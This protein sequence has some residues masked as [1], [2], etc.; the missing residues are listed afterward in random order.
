MVPESHPGWHVP[1]FHA[2]AYTGRVS[3][4]L[5]AIVACVVA[6]AAP[7]RAWCEASCQA[8]AESHGHCPAHQSSTS[9]VLDASDSSCP[10]L[11]TARPTPPARVEV[12][13][14]AIVAIA[15]IVRT[16]TVTAT[17]SCHLPDL[18]HPVLNRPLRI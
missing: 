3:R 1:P 18:S 2:G 9:P 8:P 5:I 14:P 11:D 13:S 12:A 6:L 7:A 4:V 17:V 16:G 15:P 10:V